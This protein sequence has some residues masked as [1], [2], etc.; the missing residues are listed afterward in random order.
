MQ[1]EA[2]DSGN[3][4]GSPLISLAFKALESTEACDEACDLLKHVME[5]FVEPVVVKVISP[6]LIR[7]IRESKDL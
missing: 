5:A 3:I 6:Y 7:G 4:F 1:L 2:V